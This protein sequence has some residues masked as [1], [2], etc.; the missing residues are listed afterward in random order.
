M[1]VS[2]K[3]T[4][5]RVLGQQSVSKK[6]G[7]FHFQFDLSEL[8]DGAYTVAIVSGNDESAHPVTLTTKPFQ[9][10]KRTIALN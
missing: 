1:V 10:V 3:T 6:Q 8:E 4:D 5:G 2:L 7:N 9:S